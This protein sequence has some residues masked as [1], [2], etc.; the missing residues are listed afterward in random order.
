MGKFKDLTGKKFGRLYAQSIKGKTR[1]NKRYIYHCVCDCGN[2]CD[3]LGELLSSGKTKSCGCLRK[4]T[5][6]RISRKY[7][8]YDLSGS[9]GIGYTTNTNEKFYFDLED[10]EKI[11]DFTWLISN[12]YI[13]SFYDNKCITMSR[14]L[15]NCPDK[16]VVD[17]INHIKTDNRKN[18]L[19]IVTVSQNGMNMLPPKNKDYKCR[20]L[21]YNKK[22]DNWSVR[23]TVNKHRITIGTFENLTDAI[24]AR[25]EAEIKYFGE[26]RYK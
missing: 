9:C 2:E 5:A 8:I 14:L 12:G 19:R 20:G 1:D 4:E 26:Y 23:I 25:K 11:K 17:H 15:L 21:F 10:Y 16:F 13:V 3:V 6:S 22:S 24:A 7:N 18:N